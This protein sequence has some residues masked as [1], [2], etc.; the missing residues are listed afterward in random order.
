MPKIALEKIAPRIGS[1]YPAPFHEA[2]RDRV[3]LA[4]GDAA[5][6]S[7]FGVNLVRLPPGAWS[8][9]R[10]WHSDEDE[11][12]Y[13]L[14]GEL[15]LVTDKGAETLGAGECAGFAKGVPDGHH[16]INESP[17]EAVYLE[18]GTRSRTDRCRYPDIDLDLSNADG[19]FRRKDGSP[20]P[21]RRGS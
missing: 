4:L 7:D 6:L 2:A 12:V 5:D 18:V 1:G 21:P 19:V 13:V 14:E 10:H 15:T 17:R 20:Y 11:F 9:Q 8:S 16:F 3:K